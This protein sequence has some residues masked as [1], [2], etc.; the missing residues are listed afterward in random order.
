[1]Y[2]TIGQLSNHA[3][4]LFALAGLNGEVLLRNTSDAPPA[5]RL[6][7]LG[8]NL[9]GNEWLEEHM[10]GNFEIILGPF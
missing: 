3:I 9:N 4:E 6:G 8:G 5:P 10:C 1:M 2:Y 7:G